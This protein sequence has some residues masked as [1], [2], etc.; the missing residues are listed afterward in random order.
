MTS[1]FKEKQP[2]RKPVIDKLT[3]T[4]TTILMSWPP[5]ELR[6]EEVFEV[7][8]K[9]DTSKWKTYP[10][11]WKSNSA[12]I[13]GLRP[14]TSYL[15]KVKIYNQFEDTHEYHSDISDAVTTNNADIGEKLSGK[16]PCFEDIAYRNEEMRTR[17]MVLRMCLH[18]HNT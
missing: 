17:K 4:S 13:T 14:C 16:L 8:Y 10:E 3:L 15:F 12:K 9:E 6:E 2:S 7:S 11:L 5:K 1:H 18:F